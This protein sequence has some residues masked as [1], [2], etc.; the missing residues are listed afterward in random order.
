MPVIIT[1]CMNISWNEM[2]I[3][4]CIYFKNN[5]LLLLCIPFRVHYYFLLFS[6]LPGRT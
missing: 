5:F 4:V 1:K 3:H 6:N 2:Y